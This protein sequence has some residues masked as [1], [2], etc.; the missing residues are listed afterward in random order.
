MESTKANGQKG[1]FG[2]LL[3]QTIP[4]G[5]AAPEHRRQADSADPVEFGT[6]TFELRTHSQ[7]VGLEP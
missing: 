3:G 7:R 6:V 2:G 4:A 1:S 5:R